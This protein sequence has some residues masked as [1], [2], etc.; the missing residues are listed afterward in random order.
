MKHPAFSSRLRW[1]IVTAAL[2]AL[3][4]CDDDMTPT[5]P[6]TAPIA[7]SPVVLTKLQPDTVLVIEPIRHWC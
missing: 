5:T 6:T 1:L 4:G 2:V 7:E 3:V